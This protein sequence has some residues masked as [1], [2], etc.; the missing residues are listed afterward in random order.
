LVADPELLT[1]PLGPVAEML[2]WCVASPA[3]LLVLLA[4]RVA[5]E[6]LAPLKPATL[7]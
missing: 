7:P 5:L 2:D 6:P 4:V 3:P 1:L